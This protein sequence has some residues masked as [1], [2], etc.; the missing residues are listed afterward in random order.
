MLLLA[1]CSAAPLSSTP[2]PEDPAPA[3]GECHVLDRPEH[4]AVLS[5]T[6]PTVECG[7]E[8]TTETYMIG[9]LASVTRFS[10][11]Y[12][13]L[14]ERLD[15][16]EQ[17]CSGSVVRA[18]VGANDRQALYGLSSMA[19]LPTPEQWATGERWVRCDLV[20]VG[21]ETEAFWPVGVESA[22]R[23]AA[24][25]GNADPLLR[26][27]TGDADVRCSEPHTSRDINMWIPQTSEPSELE[28]VQ[29]CV[30]AAT[31]WGTLTGRTVEGVSGVL[32]TESNGGLTLRCVVTEDA[33]V[34][35]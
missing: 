24:A 17:A 8:H 34:A 26:C 5:D 32:H 3:V 11:R 13:A 1:A 16:S 33:D 18:Y 6:S 2:S 19:F 29:Q 30:P 14:E 23:D 20:M 28:I 9:D 27:Y 15:I 31:E 10:G 4:F 22:F 12:P 35:Q 7:A 21:S 25:S